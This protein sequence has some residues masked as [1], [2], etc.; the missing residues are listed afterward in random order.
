MVVSKKMAFDKMLR[1]TIM[2]CKSLSLYD[3]VYILVE[4]RALV[5]MSHYTS[6]NEDKIAYR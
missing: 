4:D 3:G 1:N 6:Y 5:F 2:S